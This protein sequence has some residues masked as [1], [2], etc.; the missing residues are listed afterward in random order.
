M[1]EVFEIW[2]KALMNPFYKIENE[3]KSPIFRSRV[4]TAGRK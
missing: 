1:N 4:V 3:I 2:I